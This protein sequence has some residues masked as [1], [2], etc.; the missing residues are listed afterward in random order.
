MLPHSFNADVGMLAQK[1]ALLERVKNLSTV[2][3]RQAGLTPSD[4]L[5]FRRSRE[6]S[7]DRRIMTQS[8]P[9]DGS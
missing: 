3:R 2:M 4:Q 5:I 7:G 1:M 6:V 9:A 8:Q